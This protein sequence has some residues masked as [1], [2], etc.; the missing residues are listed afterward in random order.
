M[1]S[2]KA[3]SG[4]NAAMLVAILAALIVIY[5]LFLPSEDRLNIIGENDS[6]GGRG[7]SNSEGKIIFE[8]SETI[9][10]H[11]GDKVIEHDLPSVN[12][13]TS[14]EAGVIKEE[15][16]IY[17]KNGLFDKQVKEMDFKI[18]D[19]D[20]TKNILISFYAK[21]SNGRLIITVNDKEVYNGNVDKV[22]VDPIKVSKDI[23]AQSNTLKMEVSGV[24]VAFWSTNEY[25]LENFKITADITDTSTRES[26]LKFI[27]PQS[28]AKNIEKSEIRFVPECQPEN[29]G[30]LDILINNNM[31]YSSVPD[32]GVPRPLEFSSSNIITGE[33]K[34]TFRSER[35]RY[36]ID[37]IRIKNSLIETPSYTYFFDI[38]KEDMADIEKGDKVANL[39][40]FFVDDIEDK[41]AEIIING[42]KAYM[43]RHDEFEWSKIIDNYVR[44][45][46]N[47]IKIVPEERLEIGRFQIEIQDKD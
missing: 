8:G 46:S 11:I 22:N 21:K 36:L 9:M 25:L 19:P 29:V 5:I 28:E 3:Q 38:D 7:G 16:S 39:T 42:G 12:L 2:K 37:T 41:E 31:I 23:I 13:Y 34:L 14:T 20:N 40:F 24:G 44:E 10:E 15:G 18:K 17:V 43:S 1:K 45:G 30:V 35:G 27:V 33:N 32:C 47:S 26:E 6:G 4:M